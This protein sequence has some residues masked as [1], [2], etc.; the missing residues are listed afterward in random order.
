MW[1]NK[2]C[3]GID[4]SDKD[5]KVVELR[6]SGD[7]YEVVQAARL[8]V[9]EDI[10]S[11]LKH[12]LFQTSTQP[13]KVVW[14]LPTSSCSIKFA[15][16]PKTSS[17]ETARMARYEAENQIPL[18]LADL[19]WG[20]S[21]GRSLDASALSHVVIAGVRRSLAEETIAQ[22][23]PSKIPLAAG[24]V[25]ALAEVRS[26]SKTV[27]K[28]VRPVLLIDIGN[29]W[30]DLTT[31]KDGLVLACRSIHHGVGELLTAVSKDLSI[32]LP[33]AREMISQHHVWELSGD[34]SDIQ[35]VGNWVDALALEVRRSALAVIAE[36]ADLA[37]LLG[38]GAFL[39][40]L[41]AALARKASLEVQVGD[42]WAGMTLSAVAAHNK[43]D[44]SA[45]FAVATGL[46]RAG[47]ERANIINLMPKEHWEEE[48]RHRKEMTWLTAM[49]V[50]AVVL[51][52][53]LLTGHSGDDNKKADI[54]KLDREI[55]IAKKHT[56]HAPPG[57]ALATS[58]IEEVVN[59][60]R[61][62]KNSPVNILAKLCKQLPSSCRLN[63]FRFDS[64][65]YVIL[66]GSALSDSAVA[67]AV[68]KL[69][70]FAEFDA[71]ST[72][73]ANAGRDANSQSYDFQIKCILP[74][75]TS[76]LQPGK[77]GSSTKVRSVAQ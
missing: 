77:K 50:A 13:S 31:V 64:G 53:I 17:A 52:I 72:D 41:D 25:S 70:D 5:I 43:Q 7:R 26:M 36:P 10:E 54:V 39:P 66:R 63:E 34:L 8:K 1:Q 6:K 18:P 74:P 2:T 22:L 76:L 55:A 56:A 9:G 21:S 3:L 28:H 46:A 12:F 61:S 71:V 47:L 45:A 35:A 44:I 4:I 11:T 16:L 68:K 58:N 32:S 51:L 37:V 19:I 29:E 49:G 75:N 73:Y 27:R 67:D 69:S 48:I 24:M 57:L 23:E 40:G 30:T 14:S 60:L 62:S 33:E 15:R 20:Y 65:K 59:D 38:D 42:P